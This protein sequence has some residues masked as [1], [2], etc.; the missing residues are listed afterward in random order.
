M[1]AVMTSIP[2]FAQHLLVL[3]QNNRRVIKVHQ[4]KNAS[5]Y[6]SDWPDTSKNIVKAVLQNDIVS[7]TPVQPADIDSV[8][9]VVSK[10]NAIKEEKV[11]QSDAR[12]KKPKAYYGQKF[13]FGS[14]DEVF[15]CGMSIEVGMEIIDI[16]RIGFGVGGERIFVKGV[17]GYGGQIPIFLSFNYNL[18]KIAVKSRVYGLANVGYN[19]VPDADDKLGNSRL[20]TLGVGICLQDLIIVEGYYKS[21][22]ANTLYQDNGRSNLLGINL[23]FLL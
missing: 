21:Q 3:K 17:P 7:L 1:I 19:I 22:A 10:E 2:V 23:G 11:K 8:F 12:G 4:E 18:L 14:G 13:L 6:Y 15:Q 20:W 5:V 16:C 9:S